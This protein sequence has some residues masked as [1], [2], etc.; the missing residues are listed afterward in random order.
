MRCAPAHA[1]SLGL[2]AVLLACSPPPSPSAP[3][4]PSA[5]AATSSATPGASAIDVSGMDPSVAPGQDFFGYVNGGWVKSTPIPPDRAHYGVTEVLEETIEKRNAD[6]FKEIAAA[7]AP[8]GSELAKLADYYASFLDEAAVEA[9][10]IRPLAPRL[11]KIRA[12][13]NKGDLARYLGGTLRADVDILNNTD[14]STD[15]I[16]GVWV[17]QDLNDPSKYAPFLVQG[18]L[19]M[20]DRDYYLTASPRMEDI[21]TKYRAH[22]A[23]VLTLL[24]VKDAQAKAGR[25]FDLEKKIAEVHVNREDSAD[26][27]KGNNHVS[28]RDLATSAPGMDWSAFLGAAA[29]DKETTFVVWQPSATKGISALVASQPLDVWK[30]YL[31]FHAALHTSEVL[32][33]AF[34]DEDFAF[35]GK[36]LR[37]TEKLKD[38]WKRGIDA[39]NHALGEAVGKLFVERWFPAAEKARVDEMV[40][41]IIAAFAKRIDAI[42]WMAKETKSRAKAKLAVLKVGIGYPDKWRDYSGLE[43]VRGDAFGNAERAEM[44]EY[45][46][47]LAKLGRPVDRGEWVFL[48][49]EV[50]AVNLPAMN[51][52]NFPAAILQPPFLDPKRPLPMDYG[53]TG[54]TIG[55]EICHSFDDTGALFDDAGRVKNW[56]TKEDFAHFKTAAAELVKQ[57]DAYR[58][59]PDAAVNGKLTLGENIADVAGLAAAY[60]AYR[61]AFESHQAP[62]VAGLT[63]DQ[64]FFLSYAWSWREKI[65]EP[66]LRER[67]LT[68]GHAPAEY[69]ADVVRN[70]DVWYDA[71]NVKPGQALFLAPNVRVRVW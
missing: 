11:D 6:L 56:W 62:S 23:A 34:V 27:E 36:T 51:A 33:K 2:A 8:A 41:N 37:G 18:G 67:L 58:P 35:Y 13:A 4:A 22:V 50:N 40:K 10:G 30:D 26:V 45:K 64:Q 68:D 16:F 55:H 20:P 1:L 47:N 5:S 44:F 3:P 42:D 69:R 48:P 65:R 57:F 24:G 9:K 53:A 7:K 17:A 29:L 61:V 52:L 63:G 38:R 46:R 25:V 15:D 21:R 28:R 70:L 54:A 31:T 59:F 12:I 66:A 49:Q 19:G 39:T 60:D 14:L 32:P 43:V 71:F